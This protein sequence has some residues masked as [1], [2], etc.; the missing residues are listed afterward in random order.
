MLDALAD[1]PDDGEA[2]SV[3]LP[4]LGHYRVMGEDLTD[5]SVVSGLPAG[6]VDDTLA[7]LVALD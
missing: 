3:D 5:G 1:V 4:G 6:D 7:S 2:H